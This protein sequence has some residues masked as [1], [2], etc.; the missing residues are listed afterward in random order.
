VVEGRASVGV[1]AYYGQ[2]SRSSGLV[3]RILKKNKILPYQ[4]R[5]IK[6]TLFI[7]N[8]YRY[9]GIYPE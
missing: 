4:K 9:L 1:E 6:I 8:L 2:A 7:C 3:F 5:Y